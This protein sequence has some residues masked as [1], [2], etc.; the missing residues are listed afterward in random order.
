MTHQATLCQYR[1]VV[2][3]ALA[4]LLL[5]LVAGCSDSDNGGSVTP[6]S[7]EVADQFVAAHNAV[8]AAV[9]EP[10]SYSGTW[11][12]LPP[13]T[14]SETVALSAQAWA[15]HLRDSQ[16]CGLEHENNTGYGENLAMGSNLTPLDAMAMWAGEA[17]NYTYNP[18]YAWDTETGHFTQ[19]VWRATTEIGCGMASC[20]QSVVIACRYSPPG[21][22]I[23]DQPY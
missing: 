7:G 19:L 12:P 3:A 5:S 8:R 13:V 16:N 22:Y 6:L 14:W 11:A 15:N 20:S 17:S 1:T 18:V 2:A 23:G 4:A 10:A 9:T 21:N